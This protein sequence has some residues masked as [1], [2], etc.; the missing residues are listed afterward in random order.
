[1][2]DE[3]ERIIRPKPGTITEGIDHALISSRHPPTKPKLVQQTGGHRANLFTVKGN[4]VITIQKSY[5]KNDKNLR[6]TKLG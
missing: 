5:I 4:A 3:E 6:Q 2:S 1:M